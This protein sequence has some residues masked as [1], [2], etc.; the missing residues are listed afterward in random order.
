[1]VKFKN[2]YV[3]IEEMVSGINPD[4]IFSAQNI[5]NKKLDEIDNIVNEYKQKSQKCIAETENLVTEKEVTKN[6][7]SKKFSSRKD[8]YISIYN[9]IM[10][11]DV[12]KKQYE[13][14][15]EDIKNEKGRLYEKINKIEKVKDYL[16]KNKDSWDIKDG[17]VQFDSLNRMTEYYNLVN[18][19]ID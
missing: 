18:Q 16:E 13:E 8:Y 11:S 19:L 5:K 7:T 3:E 17:Q 1:M 10:L 12:M 2:I 4:S 15:E 14:I 6:I 9:T